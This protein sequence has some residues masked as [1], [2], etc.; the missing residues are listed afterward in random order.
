[1]LLIRE[2]AVKGLVI[3]QKTNPLTAPNMEDIHMLMVVS[4]KLR[5][6]IE[7]RGHGDKPYRTL[8]NEM[9]ISHVPL[10]KMLNNQPYNPSL[11]MLD[12]LCTFLKCDPGDIL[13]HR[14]G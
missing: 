10:W 11:E 1:M 14:K 8:A 12:K 13:K 2:H 7:K 5:E 6:A 4:I 9:G 3:P